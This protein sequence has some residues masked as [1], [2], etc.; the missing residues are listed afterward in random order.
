MLSVHPSAGERFYLRLLLTVVKGARSWR[1]LR[2]VGDVEYP[3][4]KDTCRARGLLDDDGEWDQCLREAGELC[5]G[6]PVLWTSIHILTG[7]PWNLL[8]PLESNGIYWN[9]ME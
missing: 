2:M 5:T 9:P 7:L 4:Y 6:F 1:D 3:T 8:C